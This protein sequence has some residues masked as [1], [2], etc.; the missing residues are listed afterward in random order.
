M[1]VYPDQ[2]LCCF[3]FTYVVLFICVMC[4]AYLHCAY[5]SLCR[6]GL[7]PQRIALWIYWQA[8]VLLA[9]GV[10]L[11]NPP[12]KA[13]LERAAQVNTWLVNGPRKVSFHLHVN[14]NGPLLVPFLFRGQ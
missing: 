9:M 10:P 2:L 14:L 4:A 8:M 3:T 12:L 5:L 11:Y 7:Q 6:Y 13:V 1:Q